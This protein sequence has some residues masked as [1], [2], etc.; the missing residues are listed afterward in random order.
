MLAAC[1][2]ERAAE[3]EPAPTPAAT[4]AP[5]PSASPTASSGARTVSEET[6][7]FLFEYAYPA[8]AGD[9]PA[10]AA[11]LDRRLEERRTKLAA[12]SATARRQARSDGFPYNKHSYSA[13]WAVVTEL[14]RFLSLSNSVTTYGGGAHGNVGMESLVWDKQ[15]ETAMAG[16]ALFSSAAALRQSLGERYCE[17]LNVEREERRAKPEGAGPEEEEPAA[18]GADEPFG[19][20]PQI[21]ELTVLLGSSSG[22][23]FDR[24]T[25]YAGPYVAGPYAEGPYAIDL[26][27]DRAV[28]EA[29]RPEYR[30]A[31]APRN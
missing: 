9:I 5:A 6:D 22:R 15:R 28:A 24:L 10:L 12:S 2:G 11:L 18:E 21:T 25:L 3:P 1:N 31:F 13:E 17:A 20:C 19:D 30:G 16:I 23:Q 4:P 27:I 8:T 29:V 7:D 26:P 14:P